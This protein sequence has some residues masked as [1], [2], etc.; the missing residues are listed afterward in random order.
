MRILVVDDEPELTALV[1]RGLRAEGHEVETASDGVDALA[2]TAEQPVDVA[3]VDL[4]MPGMDGLELCRWL[5]RRDAHVV[6]ILLTA[7][8]G[9]DDRVRG[10]DEGADDYMVKPFS[11]AELAARIRAIHRRDALAPALR[12][13]AGDLALDLP[14]R[15]VTA[16]GRDLSLSRTEFDVLHAL[17]AAAPEVVPRPALLTEV[18]GAADGVD[19]NVL[20]QYVSYL[21]RKLTARGTATRILTVR[22]VGYR[23]A[24][25]GDLP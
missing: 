22:G 14:R 2:R 6:V 23:L 19:P 5:K 17:A 7:R 4:M 9:V 21:R 13:E 1:A 25:P 11:L 10:L 20:D 18:W 8:D 24:E 15:A 12:L 16:A 3:V